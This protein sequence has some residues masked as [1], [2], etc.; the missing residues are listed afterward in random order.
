MTDPTLS[1]WIAVL[2]IIGLW[3]VLVITPG[4]NFLATLHVAA[5]RSRRDGLMV[6]AGIAVG[7]LIWATA[8]LAGLG[9]LF[10]SA[11][12][13]YHSVRI[14]GAFYLVFMGV[15]LIGSAV[16]APTATAPATPMASGAMR[17]FRL[18]FVTDMSNPK[19]AAF[20]TSLFAVAL[21]PTATLP[22]QMAAVGIV[23]AIVIVWYGL[24]ALAMGSPALRGFYSRAQRA[25]TALS[26]M[27]FAAFGIR[28][29]ANG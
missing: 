4:P 13:L 20:F 22:L 27:L 11:A 28:L 12:W 6:V 9:L 18:G 10:Q 3:A 21:P 26:G 8:S 1:P 7:T 17:A 24:V 29:A 14:A 5:T 16:Q 15:M 25:I 2:T 19:A 23:V